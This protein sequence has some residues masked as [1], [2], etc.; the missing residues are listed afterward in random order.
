MYAH[1]AP[2]FINDDFTDMSDDELKAFEQLKLDLLDY[3]QCTSYYVCEV[4]ENSWFGRPEIGGN[5]LGDVTS[6]TIHYT[7]KQ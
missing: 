1:L 7:P 5:L 2:A 3:L 6:F 4:S